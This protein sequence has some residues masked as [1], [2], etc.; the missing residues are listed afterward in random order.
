MVGGL[1]ED[2]FVFGAET[3][4]GLRERDLIEDYEVG[5]DSIRLEAGASV[6]S[7]RE[8]SS[9]VVVFLEGDNDAIYVRGGGVTKDN[10]DIVD[11]GLFVF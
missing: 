10:L 1:G 11:D 3:S 9:A 6:A 2:V 4:N 7:I 5:I 8:T